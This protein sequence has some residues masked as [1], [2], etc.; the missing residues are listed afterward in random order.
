MTNE[1]DDTAAE[2]FSALSD[3]DALG[4][5]LADLHTDLHGR[6]ARLKYISDISSVL[7]EDGSIIFGGPIASVAL[8]EAR[9]SFVLGNFAATVLMC[10]AMAENNLAGY[11]HSWHGR[12]P[13]K[14][15][16]HDTLQRSEEAGLLDHWQVADLKRLAGLRNPLSHFRDPH[17]P[18]NLMRRSMDSKDSFEEVI[19]KDA[20]FA[21]ATIIKLIAAPPFRV[22]P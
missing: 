18:A 17:D 6:V 10:Q 9:S 12:L 16:F 3:T 1:Y 2:L 15:S 14:I 7:S 19:S 20:H 8:N 11:L 13:A 22:G 21:I 5:L 4:M